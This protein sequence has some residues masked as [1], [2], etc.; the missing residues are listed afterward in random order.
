M[1]HIITSFS[2]ESTILSDQNKNTLF[3]WLSGASSKGSYK[4]CWNSENGDT[5]HQSCGGK[6]HT[7][8]IA[9]QKETKRIYGGYTD[10]PWN[11]GMFILT[12]FN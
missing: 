10:I 4:L 7:I 12:R 6:Q 2:V 5:F 3:N 9:Q 8:M 1:N 11:T